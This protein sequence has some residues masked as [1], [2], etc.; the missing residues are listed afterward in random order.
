[1]SRP[2]RVSTP[3]SPPPSVSQ[4]PQSPADCRVGLLEYLIQLEC[5][6]LLISTVIFHN[7]ILRGEEIRLH[8][9]YAYL[10]SN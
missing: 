5:P 7:F 2:P 8:I 6:L 10:Y 3:R 1:M 4:L 9:Y